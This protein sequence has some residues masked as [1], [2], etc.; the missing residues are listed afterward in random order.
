MQMQ[1]IHLV[2]GKVANFQ[3]HAFLALAFEQCQFTHQG[4]DKGRFAGAVV[5]QQTQ[6]IARMQ[7]QANIGQ[8]W[9]LVA[10]VGVRQ[11]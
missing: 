7:A 4:L 2:L 10:H 5:S 9:R 6:A 8:H 11:G 3:V 1:V